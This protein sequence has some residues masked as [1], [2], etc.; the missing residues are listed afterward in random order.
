[1]PRKIKIGTKVTHITRDSD[2]TFKVKG[3]RSK[4]TGAG[5]IVAAP[6]QLVLRNV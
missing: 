4:V 3:Q 1:M 5:H 2:I 6:A